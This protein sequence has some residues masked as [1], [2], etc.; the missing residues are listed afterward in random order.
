MTISPDRVRQIALALDGTIDQSRDERLVFSRRG[1]AGYAWTFLERVHP[2]KPR[3]PRPGVLAV[4]CPIG[5]KA[6]L[7]D[8]APD[9]YFDD[10]HYL[11]YPAILVRLDVIPEDEL[12]A[13][14][15]DAWRL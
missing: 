8:L 4:R 1:N 14:L 13:I 12:A 2:R 3:V 11:G 7:L 6:V 5:R 10:D 15:K 9:I